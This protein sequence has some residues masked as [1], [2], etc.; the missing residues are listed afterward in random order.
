MTISVSQIGRKTFREK[1]AWKIVQL[2]QPLYILLRIRRQ[3]WEIKQ[4][5]LAEMP[6]GSLGY[7]IHEWL[8]RNGYSIIPRV[9]FHDVYHVLMGF[10]NQMK[11]EASIQFCIVGN[12][13]ITLPY[14]A[15][16]AVAVFLFPEYWGTFRDAYWKGRNA[17]KFYHLDWKLLLEMDLNVL[18]ESIFQEN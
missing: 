5:K 11:H 3:P 18:Q 1:L 4:E 14:L 10:D 13:K 7:E 2:L 6:V 9:E 16:C 12:G 17:K 8:H 15:S